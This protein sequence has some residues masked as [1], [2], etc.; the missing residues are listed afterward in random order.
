MQFFVT[1]VNVDAAGRSSEWRER[2]L[3]NEIEKCIWGAWRMGDGVVFLLKGQFV[4]SKL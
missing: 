1:A 4:S 3:E 2:E